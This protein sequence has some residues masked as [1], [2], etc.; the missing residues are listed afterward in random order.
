MVKKKLKG[1]QQNRKLTEMVFHWTYCPNRDIN[2][3]GLIDKERRLRKR[4]V[5]K[6][7]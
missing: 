4:G 6:M 5:K 2:I 3:F 1:D 7:G